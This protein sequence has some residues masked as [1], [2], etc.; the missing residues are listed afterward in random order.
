MASSFKLGRIFGVDVGIHWSWVFIFFFVTWSFATGVLENF[1]PQ[2]SDPQRWIGGAFV[3]AIFFLSVLAHEL[4]HAIVSNRNRLPVRSITLFVFG[5]VANLTQEPDTPGLE[6]RIAIVGPLTSLAL[7][8]MFALLFVALRPFSDGLAGICANLAL[9]NASL[10]LFNMLPGFPLDGGRV[11]RSIVWARNHNR[12]R[13]TRTAARMGEW[14]AYAIM[15]IGI[16]YTYFGGVFN[17]LWFL[18]IGFF[19]RNASSASYEQL[20]IETTLSGIPV[21]DVMQTNISTVPPD[22]SVEELVHEHLLRHNNRCF[23]VMAAGDFAGI[24]TLS[25][26]RKLPRDQWPT[27]SVYRAM[28]PANRLHTID[29]SANLAQVLHLMS[30]HDVNQLPVL[31]GRELVGILHRSDV[32]RF[33]QV[34]RDLSDHAPDA[35]ASPPAETDPR[36]DGIASGAR[37]R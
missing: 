28:T 18:F 1:Y 33:I 22:L 20:V 5:G 6:F 10:A 14:I 17:G 31:R 24:I 29:P 2:W 11:F 21:R 23:A 9:I 7:G 26:V 34:R 15:G 37:H 25:D 16:V 36:S 27:T 32:M 4:S 8:G 30:E 3:A 12:L 13:A 35:V 19:L